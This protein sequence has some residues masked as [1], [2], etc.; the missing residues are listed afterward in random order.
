VAL[1]ASIPLILQSTEPG[2]ALELMHHIFRQKFNS[3]W[4]LKQE[5]RGRRDLRAHAVITLEYPQML[6]LIGETDYLLVHH[7]ETYSPL[8][9][10]VRDKL[11]ITPLSAPHGMRAQLRSFCSPLIISF[12][13]PSP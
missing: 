13:L 11:C 3:Y 4:L 12:V 9:T 8:S 10:A 5:V 1:R 7:V 6:E 2:L